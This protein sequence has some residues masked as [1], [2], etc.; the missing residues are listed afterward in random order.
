MDDLGIEDPL[1]TG[2]SDKVPVL[3]VFAHRLRDGRLSRSGQPIRAAHV[4]DEVLHVAKTFAEL[5][6]PDPR[7][8]AA[9]NMDYRLSSL[10][11]AY[12]NEDPAPN[13][14]KP[15]PIQVLHRSQ[16]LIDAQPTALDC[17]VADM[18]W[19]AFFYLLRPGEYCKSNENTPPRS[20]SPLSL[21]LSL[22]I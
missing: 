8:D 12:A 20:L 5:G 14:V 11:R 2:L 7:L 10:Y 16:Q 3:R 6:A 22:K 1:L 4:R 15:M 9:G 17:C 18:Q 21:S 13:R 19:I